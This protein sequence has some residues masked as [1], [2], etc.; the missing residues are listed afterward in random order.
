MCVAR[1]ARLCIARVSHNV[2]LE[3]KYWKDPPPPPH[4]SS[5][6]KSPKSQ[7]LFFLRPSGP[8]FLW[9]V[10]SVVMQ[11]P[12]PPPPHCHAHCGGLNLRTPR[13]YKLWPCP[14]YSS[15][16]DR[17]NLGPNWIWYQSK[18]SHIR[19]GFGAEFASYM[20]TLFVFAH[21]NPHSS[22][23]GDM[24]A[25]YSPFLHQL[26]VQSSLF[27]PGRLRPCPSYSRRRDRANLGLLRSFYRGG[28]GGGGLAQG[29][30]Q[31]RGGVTV[32]VPLNPLSCSPLL[33]PPQSGRGGGGL[34]AQASA[35]GRQRRLGGGAG[36]Y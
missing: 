6:S 3:P 36:M 30:G 29:L 32:W 14:S 9:Q 20:D 2:V 8:L 33:A 18:C 22:D 28:G 24:C 7:S 27:E 15:R 17:I 1:L 19:H 4:P 16:R 35:G 12:P 26:T 23:F 34:P 21:L 11:L 5:V 13:L 25:L 10:S 31:G